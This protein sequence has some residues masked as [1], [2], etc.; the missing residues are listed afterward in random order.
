M[1]AA[2]NLVECP[3]VRVNIPRVRIE[4]PVVHVDGLDAG[5]D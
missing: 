1:P 2:F 3:R 5:L 4:V